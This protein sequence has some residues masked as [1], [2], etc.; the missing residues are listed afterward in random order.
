MSLSMFQFQLIIGIC[1]AGVVAAN[2][3]ASAQAWGEPDRGSPGDAMIQNYLARETERLSSRI[4]P[5]FTSRDAWEANRARYVEEYFYM[6]GLS[7]KPERTPLHATMTGKNRVLE[8][9]IQ[10]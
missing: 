10:N 1:L 9:F 3:V 7:P 2:N 4:V 8:C 6:L 5:D